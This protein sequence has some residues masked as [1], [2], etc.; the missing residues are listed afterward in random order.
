[1]QGL[2]RSIIYSVTQWDF[3]PF[4]ETSVRGLL[5]E[6]ILCKTN[7]RY[8]FKTDPVFFFKYYTILQSVV[9]YILKNEYILC[10]GISRKKCKCVTLFI[11]WRSKY[12]AFICP[13]QDIF[14]SIPLSFVEDLMLKCSILKYSAV[15]A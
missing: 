5:Y 13:T 2:Y 14:T 6:N 15:F 8:R 3:I 1:M 4:T 7:V 11:M 10:N 9:P 12:S